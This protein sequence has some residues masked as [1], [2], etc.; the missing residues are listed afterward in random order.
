MSRYLAS[1]FWSDNLGL[2]SF[3]SMHFEL[4]EAKISFDFFT[5]L[6]KSNEIPRE[7][8]EGCFKTWILCTIPFY[9]VDPPPFNISR[10]LDDHRVPLHD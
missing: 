1:D 8:G 6:S 7:H 4:C 3:D 5:N 9:S 10:I 2:S